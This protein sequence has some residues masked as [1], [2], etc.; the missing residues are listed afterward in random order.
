MWARRGDSGQVLGARFGIRVGFRRR[1][2]VLGRGVRGRLGR[3]LLG[4]SGVLCG[5]L[6]LFPWCVSGWCASPGLYGVGLRS[7]DARASSQV[8]DVFLINRRGIRTHC[9][10][11]V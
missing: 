7:I 2:C 6:L 9:Y 8:G 3:A 4:G 1:G 5:G 11:A 10:F